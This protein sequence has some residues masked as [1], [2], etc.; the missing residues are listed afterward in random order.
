MFRRSVVIV[1][2]LNCCQYGFSQKAEKIDSLFSQ[3]FQRS[4]FNGNVLLTEN[5]QPFYQKS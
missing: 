3:F 4:F 2:L 5:G 1:F